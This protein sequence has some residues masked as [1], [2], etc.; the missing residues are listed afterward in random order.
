MKTI[1]CSVCHQVIP[2]PEPGSVTTNYC[3]DRRTGKV[4]SPCCGKR[5]RADMLATGRAT[6]YL[7][8]SPRD[9]ATGTRTSA[10]TLSNWPGSLK[11]HCYTRV[12]R[13]NIARVR[14]DAWFT[15]AG[16]HWYGV[17]YGDNTQICRC[18]RL[19]K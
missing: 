7:T 11:F 15:I 18:R 3:L 8:T 4:C 9:P 6:L 19:K 14:Y 12:G 17:A 5:D 16:E 10:G 13:H 2:P 1:K